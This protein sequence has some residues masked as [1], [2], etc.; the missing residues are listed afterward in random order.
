MDKSKRQLWE[1]RFEQQI[2]TSRKSMKN[3]CHGLRNCLKFAD[4]IITIKSAST[5]DDIGIAGLD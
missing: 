2:N 4:S 1:E 3:I 5:N